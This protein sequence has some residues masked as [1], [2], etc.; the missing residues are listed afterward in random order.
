VQLGVLVDRTVD[1]HE[2]T[3]RFEISKVRLQICG[4]LGLSRVSGGIGGLIEHRGSTSG[5]RVDAKT[6][7][8]VA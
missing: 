2:K 4:W 6:I 3:A 8:G 5:I 7:P 1:A